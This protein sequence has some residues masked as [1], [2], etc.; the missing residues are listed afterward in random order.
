MT[1]YLPQNPNEASLWCNTATENP[2][3]DKLNGNLQ[4]DVVVI[5]GGYTG[6]STALHLAEKGVS[7]VLLEASR[8]GY[9]GS[10]RNAGLVNAGVWKTPDYV[11]EQLGEEAG[12]RFNQALYDSPDAVFDLIDRYQIDC[13]A[14]RCGTINIAHSASA[15]GYLQDRCDQLRKLG[16]SV[17]FLDGDTTRSISGSAFYSHGGI[18]DSN[19][20]TVQPLSFV[21]GL[22]AAAMEKGAQLFQESPLLSLE[23][24]ENGWL[25]KSTKGQVLADKVVLATNAYS[26]RNSQDVQESTVPVFIFQCAT[27]PLPNEI[28]DS[29]IPQRQGMWDTQILMTSSR[30]DE[31]GRLV[32][33]SAGNLA[34]FKKLVRQGWM[35]HIRNKIYPQTKGLPWQYFWTG[36]VG[37]TRNK[38]LRI[39]LLAPGVFA[40]AGYNGRGIGPGTVIGKHLAET[41]ISG[42]R[43]EFPFPVE[44][45]YKERWR[46]TRSAYY[47][48]GTLGLNLLDR[49]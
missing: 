14:N 40:P 4:A 27:A 5:G 9:G 43:N 10:G 44:A 37:L 36:Q 1:V 7:V 29:I 42:N 11:I 18:L 24:E 39:Q 33:S 17:R 48:Y 28:A 15:V 20:G 16:A 38:I 12:S 30:V 8:I 21:H 41:L 49:F 19:A 47:E 3:S 2:V 46:R 34:G 35:K 23:R 13:Q 22:A 31:A 32:M 45:L 26:D 6:L 25:A